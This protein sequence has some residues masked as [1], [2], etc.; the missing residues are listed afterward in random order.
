LDGVEVACFQIAALF[1]NRLD[2]ALA[3]FAG[4]ESRT[5]LASDPPPERSQIGLAKERARGGNIATWETGGQGSF[6]FIFSDTNLANFAETFF[7]IHDK[8][9]R[10]IALLTLP[11]FFMPRYSAIHAWDAVVLFHSNPASSIFGGS[12]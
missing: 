2:D 11:A 4:I 5:A 9:M 12:M 1:G 6:S 3:H 7:S 10:W 8:A